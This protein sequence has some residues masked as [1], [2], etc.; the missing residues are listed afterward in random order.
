MIYVKCA[1]NSAGAILLVKTIKD[2]G[3]EARKVGALPTIR[4][5]DLVVNWGTGWHGDGLNGN[6]RLA[7]GDKYKELQLFRENG[8]KTVDFTNRR[9]TNLAGWYARRHVHEDG[10]DLASG[11]SSGDYYTRHTPTDHEYRVY[12]FKDDTIGTALKIPREGMTAHPTIR[13]YG[14][15]WTYTYRLAVINRMESRNVA[16]R[17]AIKAIAAVG[18]DFGGVD[19][20]IKPDGTPVVFEVNSRPGLDSY[21]AGRFAETFM[22]Y[23]RSRHA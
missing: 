14:H 1:D 22:E 18:Y 6:C 3:G 11:T 8:V 4:R 21:S 13:S 17:E 10:N 12:V 23:A 16:R 19:V 2:S 15:G 9:P 7:P 5:G 20:G